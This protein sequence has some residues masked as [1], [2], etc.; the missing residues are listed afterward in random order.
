MTADLKPYPEYKDSGVPWLGKVPKHWHVRRMKHVFARIVGGSTPTSSE[1]AYWDG[2]IVWVTPA[3]V[4]RFDRLRQSLRNI[5]SQGLASCSTSLVPT[6]T[7]VVTSRAPVGNAALAMVELCT[8]QGCKALV[9]R[10]DLIR[11]E[12]GFALLTIMQ[13]EL[14]SLANGTTFSEISTGTLGTVRIPLTTLAE[15]NAIIRFLRVTE[16]RINRFLRAKRRMIALLREQKQ[17]IINQAVTRGLDPNVPL[18]PSGIPWLGDIPEHWEVRR[19]KTLL[20]SIDQGVSPQAEAGLAENG[21]WGVLKSGCTN[22]GVF[23]QAEHKRLPEGYP[24]SE[25]IVVREGDVLVSRACGTPR[26]V[27]STARV[28]RLNYNLILSDKNFRLN[29]LK[30]VCVDFAVLAMNADYFR[31]QISDVISGAEG[32]ANNLP[33]SDLRVLILTLPPPEQTE[34]IVKNVFEQSQA[35]DAAI[36]R[37]EREIELM[38]EYRTRLI[39]DVVTGKVDVRDVPVE[40]AVDEE[41]EDWS[42]KV[43]EENS[44]MLDATE[45]E[46]ANE[47]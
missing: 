37:A 11:S 17:A 18:K 26:L 47:C 22:H 38:N 33:L 43:P 16:S 7:I 9:P 45:E 29:F 14:Q 28:G 8:N 13:S 12:F 15:Q 32:L 42:D 19:L 41:V 1:S 2:D 39:A 5:S 21:A 44:D 6:G 40:A 35:V 24:F 3:D 46:L 27:G 34:F 25:R 30:D 10:E 20:K 31:K 4:S 23:R 36:A